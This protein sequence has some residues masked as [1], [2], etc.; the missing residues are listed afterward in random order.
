MAGEHNP[1]AAIA[2]TVG[3]TTIAMIPLIV[4]FV[5]HY[6]WVIFPLVGFMSF[7][8]IMLGLFA[9]ILPRKK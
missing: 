5:P 8:G 1:F 7:L 3:G 4:I 9:G 2:R 6:A